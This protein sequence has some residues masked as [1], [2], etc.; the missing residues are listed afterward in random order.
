[1]VAAARSRAA[2]IELQHA[3]EEELADAASAV[4]AWLSVTTLMTR[5]GCAEPCTISSLF[6]RTQ[7][8]H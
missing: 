2:C 7:T 1:V 8:P 5:E 6:L 4:L 3:A